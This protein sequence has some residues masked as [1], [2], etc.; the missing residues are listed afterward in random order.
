M[1]YSTTLCHADTQLHVLFIRV[2]A[3][4]SHMIWDWFLWSAF[5]LYLQ[6]YVSFTHLNA[7]FSE[8]FLSIVHTLMNATLGSVSWILW[9]ADWSSQDPTTKLLISR[10]PE[11]RP[12][13]EMRMDIKSILILFVSFCRT[14]DKQSRRAHC[15]IVCFFQT[16]V[17]PC[18]GQSRRKKSRSAR[19]CYRVWWRASRGTTS[20]GRWLSCCTCWARRL[21][22]KDKGQHQL[23]HQHYKTSHKASE[24]TNSVTWCKWHRFCSFTQTGVNSSKV[25]MWHRVQYRDVLCGWFDH[26]THFCSHNHKVSNKQLI[27]TIYL[28]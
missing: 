10:W 5:L 4:P 3:F 17:T 6:L 22:S 11:P 13:P 16:L 8:C 14:S 1:K 28:Q 12:H 7:L 25:C 24:K 15:W 26:Y 2:R 20:A 18:L 27:Y 23:L 19:S 21:G 9:P